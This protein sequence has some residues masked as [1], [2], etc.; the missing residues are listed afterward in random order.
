MNIELYNDDYN[1]VLKN[2]DDNN[3]DAIIADL[4]YSITNNSWDKQPINL[5]QLWKQYNRIIKDNGVIVLFAA[6]PFTSKLISSNIKMF[7]YSWIWKKNYPT[8]FLNVKKQPL[9]ITEDICVFYKKQCVYKPQGITECN[10]NIN[11]GNIYAVSTNYNPA[12][13]KYKQTQT[14]YPNNILEFKR[15]KE[16]YHPTQKPVALL[17]YLILTYTNE[18][19]LILDN[20]MGSGSTGVA[21]KNLNRKFIGIEMN[22]DY[23]NIA[24]DRIYGK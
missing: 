19:D 1:N 5:E 3:I 21:A 12:N 24:K 14:N 22:K 18:G 6:Q 9:R 13:S 4:P 7:K 23:Y 11:R 20:V 2:I 15:D 16:T 17:E 10:L 8:N